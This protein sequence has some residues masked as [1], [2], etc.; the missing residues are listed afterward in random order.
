MNYPKQIA[1]IRIP[2]SEIAQKAM[3]IAYKFSDETLFCHTMRTYVFGAMAANAR[4][5]KFDEEASFI[6]SIL[7]DL[8][9]TKEFEKNDRFELVGADAAKTFLLTENYPSE[10]IELIWDAIA[11]HT[12]A[13][14][15]MRKEPEVA[16]VH[17]GAAMDVFGLGV[18]ELPKFIFDKII[19]SLPR[20]DFKNYIVKKLISNVEKFPATTNATW[21]SDVG[22]QHVH[23]YDC[24]CVT[25]SIKS[26]IFEE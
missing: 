11:L 13:G 10:K 19:E 6:A 14:I 9:I 25:D 17:I 18:N 16:I 23:N 3:R 2:D 8:G 1:G 22:R 26:S 12:S 15:A 5:W 24:P 21:L 4:R 7:H 20:K